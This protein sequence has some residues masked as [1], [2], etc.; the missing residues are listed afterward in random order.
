MF[1]HTFRRGFFSPRNFDSSHTIPES[2]RQ[3]SDEKKPQLELEIS[4]L[5]CVAAT[6]RIAHTH[7]V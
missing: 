2:I 1:N 4:K 6:I 3:Q 5:I 7:K